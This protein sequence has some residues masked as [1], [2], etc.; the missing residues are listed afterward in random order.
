MC[1]AFFLMPPVEAS[2]FFRLMPRFHKSTIASSDYT[3]NHGFFIDSALG[4]VIFNRLS[5]A[6]ENEESIRPGLTD[7][8]CLSNSDLAEG[9]VGGYSGAG[10]EVEGAEALVA[11]RYGNAMA[12]LHGPVEPV[13]AAGSFVAE[14]EAV[15]V[16]KIGL[17]E[18]FGGFGGEEPEAFGFLRGFEEILTRIVVDDIERFPVV[19]AA[20]LEVAVGDLE[21]ER[22]N[23]VEA[24]FGDRAEPPDITRVLWN[25]R[26]VEDD[27]KHQGGGLIELV[28]RCRVSEINILPPAC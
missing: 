3:Y 17:P 27:M 16:R 21:S 10:G 20:A 15:A 22:V 7:C 9:F 4:E 1:I 26:L 23:E 19:H 18:G 8:H 11:V 28:F 13:G 6:Q 14:D 25:L 24:R 2:H 5:A 12:G